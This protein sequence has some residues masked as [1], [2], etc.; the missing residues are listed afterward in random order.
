MG[1]NDS[2]FFQ[3]KKIAIANRVEFFFALR[4]DLK[5]N[6]EPDE[7]GDYLFIEFGHNDQKQGRSGS[8]YIL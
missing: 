5:K 3:A 2:C 4:A 8:F 7:K 6:T 1:T